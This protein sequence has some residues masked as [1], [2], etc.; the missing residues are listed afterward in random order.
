MDIR[1][2]IVYYIREVIVIISVPYARSSYQSCSKKQ[3]F[4][5]NICKK[6]RVLESLFNKVAGSQTCNIIKTRL[7]HDVFLWILLNFQVTY[8]NITSGNGCQ[9]Y[10]SAFPQG[11]IL[12]QIIETQN[13]NIC[14]KP[15]STTNSNF[16]LN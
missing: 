3:L 6:T 5:E 9:C 10:V 4:L 12:Q 11:M 8:F 13:C 16:V 14:G 1:L 7:Q 2:K 15:L